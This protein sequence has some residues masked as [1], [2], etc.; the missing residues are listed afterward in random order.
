MTSLGETLTD[1]E[2]DEMISDLDVDGDGQI[3]YEGF[4]RMMMSKA[5]GLPHY[6]QPAW[7]AQQRAAAEEEAPAEALE[8]AAVDKA[9]LET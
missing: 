2:V 8:K 4:V 3:N 9:L 5:S 6:A 1:K 7:Y